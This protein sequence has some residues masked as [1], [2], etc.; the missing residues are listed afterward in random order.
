MRLHRHLVQL[1]CLLLLAFGSPAVVAQGLDW[2]GGASQKTEFLEARDVFRIEQATGAAGGTRL[3]GVVAPGYYLYRHRLK[4]EAGGR[5]LAL[6]LPQG[7]T[8]TDE[9]FGTTEIYRDTFAF[10][11]G[12]DL[13]TTATLHWQGCADDGICYPP[14]TMEVE[15]AAP[16]PRDGDADTAPTTTAPSPP[17]WTWWAKSMRRGSWHDC[18][19]SRG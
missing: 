12:N 18:D 13:A 9:F 8:T 19:P 16:L 10:G 7:Q 17:D 14:Q 15:L 1:A 2:L 3:Q 4:V 11:I 5:E 6:A